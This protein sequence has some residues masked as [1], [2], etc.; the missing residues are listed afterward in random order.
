[1]DNAT[2]AAVSPF[3]ARL[4]RWRT[5]RG[6][7]QLAL[8]T[9]V[10]ST[11]RHVSFLETGRSRPSRQ[12]VLRLGEALGVPLR[13]RN[14]LLHAAGLPVAYPQADLGDRDLA[15]YL[16]A[17][18]R[19]LQAHL[20][21]P[22][23]VIDPYGTVL[24]ANRACHALFGADIVGADLTRRFLADPAARHTI[25]NWPEVAWAGLDRLR[26]QLDRTPF[27]Q[28]LRRLVERA[29]T[30]LSGVPRPHRPSTDP[31]V[32]PWFRVGDQV[33]KTIGIAARFESAAEITLD[34]LRIEL[35][36]PLDADADRVLRN[37]VN[38]ADR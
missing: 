8:A 28:R 36:Y 14:Q 2:E 38:A 35:I 4:R 16:A 29:E 5:H 37:L 23:M 34:E 9:S 26:H 25:A 33:V 31:V 11:A 3:G 1:M 13:E 6:L 18:D 20:P 22:A 10:G 21:Y 27:D 7:S 12:M 24:L 17:V 19:L 15:P 30:T 32:C